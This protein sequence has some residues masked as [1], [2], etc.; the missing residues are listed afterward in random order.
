MQ[1][2]ILLYVYKYLSLKGVND[3]LMILCGIK[4][5]IYCIRQHRL[6]FLFYLGNNSFGS[7]ATSSE[8]KNNNINMSGILQ[9]LYLYHY[10]Y[11][12]FVD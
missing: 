3:L 9:K 6:I 1:Y 7:E 10:V 11:V 8:I 4:H 5:Q 2:K 12:L